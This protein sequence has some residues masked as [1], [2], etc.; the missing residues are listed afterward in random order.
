MRI[1]S[2]EVLGC[3]LRRR[4]RRGGRRGERGGRGGR[5]GR[6]TVLLSALRV[7]R[8]LRRWLRM[9][10]GIKGRGRKGRGRRRGGGRRGVGRVGG[11][12]KRGGTGRTLRRRVRFRGLRRPPRPRPRLPP[13]QE[14]KGVQSV[15][16]SMLCPQ[17]PSL[18]S[19]LKP[20]IITGR[21][22]TTTH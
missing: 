20:L 2:V 19:Q 14:K 5:S 17:Y 21:R 12:R 11:V 1:W 13:L 4:R 18:N 8:L 3:C 9:S 10:L 7:R 22:G 15:Q 16:R 6:R